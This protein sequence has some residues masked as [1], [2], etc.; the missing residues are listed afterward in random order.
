V[1]QI[2]GLRGSLSMGKI[3]RAF[4]QSEQLVHGGWAIRGYAPGG[5]VVNGQWGRDSVAAMLARDEFVLNAG[6]ATYAPG[7]T[8]S[9]NRDPAGTLGRVAAAGS[10]DGPE[11]V[12]LLRRI[13]LAMERPPR[14]PPGARL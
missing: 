13:A 9:Y 6:A 2:G 11:T 14:R 12:A 4:T 5:W 7:F 10:G 3:D 1:T 8:E